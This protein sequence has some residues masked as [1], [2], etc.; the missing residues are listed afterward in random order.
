MRSRNGGRCSK[1]PLEK[2][3][4][5]HIVQLLRTFGWTV[6]VLG[7]PSPADGRSHRGTGQTPGVPDLLAFGPPPARRQVWIEVKREGQQHR[8]RPAQVMFRE[9]ALDAGVGHVVGTLNNVVGWLVEHRYLTERQ[10]PWY[11][12]QEPR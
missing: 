6:Y 8:L 4:Q 2:V 3:E 12:T 11:R 10:V 5:Q 9:L 7:H 1:P